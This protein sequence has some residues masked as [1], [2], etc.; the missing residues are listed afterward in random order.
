[1]QTLKKIVLLV[2]GPGMLLIIVVALFLHLFTPADAKLWIIGALVVFFVIF[3]P[4]YGIEY[5][6]QE[7]RED[8]TKKMQF[9]KDK[10][11]MGWGGGNVH[12]RISQ[13]I[14]RPGKLFK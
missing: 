1:M 11:R 13:K 7:F 5:F 12:G 14:K 3:I 6:R 4:L 9:K 2:A 10:S 8:K